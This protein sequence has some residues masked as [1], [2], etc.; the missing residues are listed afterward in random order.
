MNPNADN[1]VTYFARTNFRGEG[2][3]FGIKQRD[4]LAHLYVIGKTGTGKSTLLETMMKQDLE[5]GVG[6]ALLDPHGDL[7][8]RV[9]AAVPDHRKAD[10]IYFN[11]PNREHP[12]TY[13]PLERVPSAKKS[14]TVSGLLEVFRKLWPEFW[15]PRLEHILRNALLVLLDQPEATL[16]D[17]L[18]LFDEKAYRHE[19]AARSPN[20]QLRRFW[21][22]EYESYPARLRA[23]AIAPIQNKVGAFLA[24]PLL[25]RILTQPKSDF[26]LREVMDGGRVLL[27]NLAKG[28][29]GEDNA[30]LVGALLVAGFH[31]AALSRGDTPESE[32]QDF[33]IY[34]DEFHSFATGTLASMMS[35]LRKFHVGLVLAHQFL[36]QLDPL[37]RDAILGNTGTI[38][39]F[40][41]GPADAEFLAKEFFPE[42]SPEDFTRLPNQEVYLRLLI[43]G[44]VSRGFSGKVGTNGSGGQTPLP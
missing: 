26:S 41:L 22:K 42:F 2:K 17:V 13:N 23:E 21:L 35:E 20:A 36:S 24:D 9:L 16:A 6:F 1:P 18:R 5:R 44:R 10:L 29:I 7:V 33:F 32:R 12:L 38:I 8:E 39:S 43:D 30:R 28:K 14:L 27:V 11:V 4:R 31:A 34:L 3:L 25:A 15:G 19:A 37:V 40:R